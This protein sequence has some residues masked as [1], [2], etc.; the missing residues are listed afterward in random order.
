MNKKYSLNDLEQ[1][2]GG[3]SLDDLRNLMDLNTLN[4]GDIEF[5]LIKDSNANL[6][7]YLYNSKI[8]N[9]YTFIAHCLVKQITDYKLQIIDLEFEWNK[10]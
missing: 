6:S 3:S 7:D 2:I 8:K 5:S 10:I 4:D 9:G 1:I